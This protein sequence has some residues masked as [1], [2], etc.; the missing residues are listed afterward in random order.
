MHEQGARSIQ[1]H[2]TKI[3]VGNFGLKLSG[4]VR[5]NRKSFENFSSPFEVDHSSRL[6]RTDRNEPFHAFDHFDPFSI[7]GPRC[8]ISSM[9]KMEENIYHC[10]FMPGL[11]TADLSVLLVHLCTVT[12]GL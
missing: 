1:I 10:T 5:S 2:S 7:P 9:Y 12:T 3:S 11:L 6:H 4:S 8:S